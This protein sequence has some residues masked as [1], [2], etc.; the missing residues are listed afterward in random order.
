MISTVAN[1][2]WLAACVPELARFH[3]AS[4]QVAEEQWGVLRRILSE[5][6]DSELGSSHDFAAIRSIAEYQEKVPLR[7][8]DG[9]KE[10]IDRAASGVP[11]VLT[12]E[13]VRLFEPTSGSSGATKLIPYTSS[14]K[15]EFQRGIRA[16]IGDLFSHCPS[17]LSGQAYWSVSPVSGEV[18]KTSGGIPIGFDDD[19]SYVGGWQRSLVK[20]VMAVPRSVQL[21]SDI[22]AFRYATLLF[23][24]RARNLALISVWNPTFLSLLLDRLPEWGDRICYDLAHGTMQCGADPLVRGR[25]PG[26]P[27]PHSAT[28]SPSFARAALCPADTRRSRE[29]RASLGSQSP[30]ERYSRLWPKLGLISCWT[31]ANAAGPAVQLQQY[32]PHCRIQGKGLISTEAFVSF[33]LVDQEHAALAIRSHFLEFLPLDSHRPQ[34]AHQLERGGFYTVAVTT[35]GGLYRYQ[36]GDLIE[37]A[38]HFKGCP[39]IRFVGRQGSV[40]DWFGEKLS[41][42]HVCQVFQETFHVFG[43]APS[44]AMLACDTDA[45]PGYVLYI[46]SPS[47]DETVARAANRIDAGLRENFHYNYARRLGQLACVRPLRVHDGA[48]SYLAEAMRNGQKLGDVKPPAL[49]RRGGWSRV[50]GKKAGR[51]DSMYTGWNLGSECRSSFQ[52]RS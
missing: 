52:V 19:T 22:D 30:E 27:F 44:F 21:A 17:L 43:M 34:L 45:P 18:R 16:W 11:N 41:E 36:L 14:L 12:R 38:G 24:V 15:N 4:R 32:F 25:P 20:A 47:D 8:Y 26:R 5:N 28:L 50:L 49:D 2:M 3:R 33:P 37:V 51:A 1:S 6:A 42:A 29:V 9:H 35:G 40:S 48:A 46:E 10:W 13:R 23:L 7:D 31:D 39:L